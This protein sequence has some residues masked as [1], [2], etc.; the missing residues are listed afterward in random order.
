[1][2]SFPLLRLA[3]LTVIALSAPA[4]HAA[5]PVAPENHRIT[6][7]TL[8]P[9][10]VPV[11]Q[12]RL[13][14]WVSYAPLERGAPNTTETTT[15]SD[16]CK[17]SGAFNSGWTLRRCTRTYDRSVSRTLPAAQM[18]AADARTLNLDFPPV[19]EDKGGVF[20]IEDV[21]LEYTT[22]AKGCAMERLDVRLSCWDEQV[23]AGEVLAEGMVFSYS[24]GA[25]ANPATAQCGLHVGDETTWA[26]QA[27][28]MQRVRGHFG[29]DQQMFSDHMLNIFT[30][31]PTRDHS[32]QWNP[33]R[34]DHTTLCRLPDNQHYLSRDLVATLPV[35]LGWP[36]RHEVEIRVTSKPDGEVCTIWLSGTDDE[37]YLRYFYTFDN[38]QLVMVSTDDEPDD[39]KREWRWA[40]GE[41]WEY[42]R[43]QMPD[44]VAGHDAILYW[45][46]VAAEQWPKQM[47]YSPDFKEFAGLKEF[48]GELV[49][50]FG[51]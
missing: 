37:T 17:S 19:V 4:L 13:K 18:R 49:E 41:P 36:Y 27:T 51:K 46:K 8:D 28:V 32:W 40:N 48:A 33:A 7:R 34:G 9:N 10:A 43:R 24:R 47:D 1:M 3:L 44:S 38:G 39:V 31:I 11:G 42:T 50:R 2:K 15:S 30:A 20:G 25:K 16:N 29:D 12:W 45:H 21:V 14:V 35:S 5:T 23:E 22:C 6:L 26:N